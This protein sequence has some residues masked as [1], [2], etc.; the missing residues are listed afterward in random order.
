VLNLK[1]A[2]IKGRLWDRQGNV[3]Q[4]GKTKRGVRAEKSFVREET[5]EKKKL[6]KEKKKKKKRKKKK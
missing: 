3:L 6:K 4:Q 1:I 2:G 5:A